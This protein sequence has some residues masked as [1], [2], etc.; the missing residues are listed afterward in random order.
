RAGAEPP[1]RTLY[2]T[3]RDTIC[4][5]YGLVALPPPWLNMRVRVRI[6]NMPVVGYTKANIRVVGT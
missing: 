1:A 6:A 4:I 2:D 5:G 3:K